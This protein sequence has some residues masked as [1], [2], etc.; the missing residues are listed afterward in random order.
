M[1]RQRHQN[2]HWQPYGYYQGQPQ[3]IRRKKAAPKPRSDSMTWSE[4]F[5][6]CKWGAILALGVISGLWVYVKLGGGAP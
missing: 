4:F 2:K 6:A 5:T 1:S 3:I